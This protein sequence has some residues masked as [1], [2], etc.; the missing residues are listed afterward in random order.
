MKIAIGSDHAG[1]E[2]KEQLKRYLEYRGFDYVDVGTNSPASVDYPE[3]AK[4]VGELV[5]GGECERGI[6][7]CGTAVGAS[8]AANK[9]PGIRAAA[10][11][12]TY[13]ARQSREHV[14]A[15]ILALAGRILTYKR[16][17][18]IV[19]VW[20]ETRFEGGRHQRRLDKIGEIESKYGKQD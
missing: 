17:E 15:N 7:I 14:D 2:L 20:L 8:V 11:G 19:D 12:D 3:Y 13:I 10:C 16:A 9:V 5:V 18:E 1:F 6:M 4:K